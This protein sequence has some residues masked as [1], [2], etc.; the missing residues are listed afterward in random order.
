MNGLTFSENEEDI[1][2]ETDWLASKPYFF[3]TKSGAHDLNK[4]MSLTG[5]L[6]N[7]LTLKESII[8]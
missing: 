5:N 8:F 4:I 7:Y 2:Y 1:L 3:N 6:V